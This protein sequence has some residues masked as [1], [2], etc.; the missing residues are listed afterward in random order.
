MSRWQIALFS[1]LVLFSIALSGCQCAGTN[2]QGCLETDEN[3]Q[4]RM[5]DRCLNEGNHEACEICN[6]P[7]CKQA[8]GQGSSSSS[9]T[10]SSSSSSSASSSSSLSVSSSSSSSA[11]QCIPPPDLY[12]PPDGGSVG[13]NVVFC[14]GSNYFLQPG[15][16][17][18]V[19]AW[20]GNNPPTSV[21]TSP[22]EHLLSARL[23]PF[24]RMLNPRKAG[25]F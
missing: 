15:E 1:I 5:K 16:V 6:D 11:A 8:I 14:W 25:V 20:Q 3:Y 10:S 13:S 9:S 2:Y 18:D 17:F 7:A 21:G 24:S 12:S 19:L 22:Y 23:Y 4:A